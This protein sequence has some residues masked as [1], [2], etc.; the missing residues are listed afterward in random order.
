M[1]S[2]VKTCLEDLCARIDEDVERRNGQ[3]WVAFLEDRWPH[4]VFTPTP[5]PPAPPRVPWP[6]ISLN[7]A[8]QDGDAMLLSQFGMCSQ[9]LADGGTNR[10]AVR[11][12]YGTGI[13]PSLFGCE[14]FAL[15]DSA[16]TLPTARPLGGQRI[17]AL[18]DAG[19]PD[20]RAG[21]GGAVFDMADRFNEVLARYP[22]LG[23]NVALYHPDTQGP[24]DLVE[25]IWGSEMFLAFCD[26]AEQ[27]RGFLGLVTDT[28][29]SFMRRWFA[30]APAPRPYCVHWGLLQR[31]PVMLRNDSLMNLSPDIYTQF[32][33]PLDQRIFDALGG[34]AVHFCGRGDHFIA[35]MSQM[36]D[37]SCIALSQPHLNDMEM[38][39]R[40]T[41]DK[42]IKLLQ[43]DR[44][45][46]QRAGRPLRGQVHCL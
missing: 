15:D 23:R 44:P 14:L 2:A 33:R 1:D 24:I 18:L 28:Y 26:D 30:L 36:R 9:L 34:G 8:Q 21:L 17:A 5:R 12:N 41:V 45:A 29:I 11:C 46:A 40:H 39:Y 25:L 20:L 3:E 16:D 35:A 43:L 19:V 32:V 38:V 10:L 22:V 31:G 7:R 27:M 13:I 4:D 6:V 42:G 37:L